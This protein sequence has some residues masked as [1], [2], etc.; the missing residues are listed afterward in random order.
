MC[1]FADGD[2]QFI[3]QALYTVA[4]ETLRIYDNS[5]TAKTGDYYIDS[6][7]AFQSYSTIVANIR[8]RVM[9]IAIETVCVLSQS[10]STC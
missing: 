9:P 4:K 8:A 2:H 1:T 7:D 6:E 3:V 10:N 5:I